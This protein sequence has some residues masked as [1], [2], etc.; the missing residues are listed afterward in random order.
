MNEK[1]KLI[2]VAKQNNVVVEESFSG[3][4]WRLEAFSPAGQR[5]KATGTHMLVDTLPDGSSA[6]YRDQS[7]YDMRYRIDFGL[8][9]CTEEGCDYCEED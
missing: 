7:R 6:K 8:E 2:K 1:A 5:F 9:S 4:Y 3:R